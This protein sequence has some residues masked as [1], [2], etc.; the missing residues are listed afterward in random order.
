MQWLVNLLLWVYAS[1]LVGLTFR[2]LMKRRPVGVT[3]AWLLFLY[4]LPGVGI[5][6]YLLFGERYLGRIR[7]QRARTQFAYYSHWLNQI[8]A[9]Q[10]TESS[11]LPP[12]MELTKA[13]VGMP[14]LPDNHWRFFTEASATYNALIE[15]ID[16][17]ESVI[18]L[19]F[20]ILEA[21][22]EVE[23]VLVALEKA[24]QRGVSVYM[25]LDSVGSN[26]FLRSARRRLL[27]QRGVKVLD[28]LHANYLRMTL[29]RQDL[30]QHRKLIA[31]DNRLAYTGSMN[32]ADPVFFKKHS[33][34]GPWI[35]MMIRLQGPIASIVQGSLIFDWEMETGTRL[36]K[37]LSWPLI[38]KD[39]P[40]EDR[41]QL[42]P[43][44]P[45]LDEE[46]LLQVLLTAIHTAKEQVLITTPYF[47]PD[48][49][50]LMALKAAAK[51]GLR[52]S[53]IVPRKNDSILAQNAGRS[54][55]DELLQAGVELLRFREG[56]LHSKMVIIDHN[57]LLMGSVNLDM[58]SIWL[59][60]ESTLIIDDE[61]VC[62]EAIA[63][64]STYEKLAERIDLARWR[65]RRWTRRLVENLA[66]LASPLL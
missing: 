21:A 33:G 14:V 55:Y 61:D 10:P 44:G 24:A 23:N 22:G 34:V 56:F 26:R 31:I 46:I 28:T 41:M 3:L 47:V 52:V 2:I 32:L 63:I 29:R 53:V 15:D 43:S 62:R 27:E 9:Q 42:L 66:Q 45:A 20:Y 7:A 51:R 37:Y 65:Q 49:A 25:M 16:Y 4:I 6:F 58:R 50:I 19:E 40:G 30:R 35:D 1:A 5:L 13:A 39:R 17:A 64:F 11:A 48:E 8:L 12:V 54:F 38:P 59:N 60:F 18:F 36:E 57:T